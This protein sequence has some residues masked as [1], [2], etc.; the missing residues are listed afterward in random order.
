MQSELEK[1]RIM[2]I[3]SLFSVATIMLTALSLASCNNRKFHVDGE[4]TNAK[5]STLYFE[6]MSLNG[7][8]V[9]DSVKLGE[10]GSFS[11]SEKAPEAPDFYRLRIAGQIINVSIDSTETVN[12]KAAYPRMASKYE[13]RGSVNCCKIKTLALMQ[14]G[15]Q[16]QI[17]DIIKSPALGVEAVEANIAS[18]LET[19][20]NKVKLNYI[21]REPM[22]AYAYFALF[23]TVIIGNQ[24]TLIFNPR[25]N[26]EDNKV[27]AAVAT[28][29]D[30]YYPKAERGL[31]L[32]NIALQGMKDA[33]ILQAE[34]Q[35]AQID[36]SKV[37][38]SG[39]I[40]IALRDNKGN[41]R[42]L[43]DLTG[44]VVMLD[45]HV[46]AG[47]NSTKR[48]MMLRD[49]YNKY[50][51]QGFEIYQVSI[52]PDEHFWK[53]QTAALPWISVHDDAGTD[54]QVLSQY[55]VQSIP[56]FFLIGKD[57]SVKMRDVQVKDIDAAI[58]SLL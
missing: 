2:K 35:Q 37:K 17:D 3:K 51:A 54:S 23:Q 10:D 26:R 29:W 27:Y 39:I 8:V 22:K 28:S 46:F 15:L 47:E 55:N 38:V 19:Y 33:R 25:N 36:A 42:R 43:S 58:K 49:L 53:T 41:L 14:Q 30:T 20:K 9:V 4:I 32:H 5:D 50:H 16:K 13:V 12:I 44:K 21:F 34:Q 45:F 48:I 7:P 11:F 1:T 24:Q 31:N 40:D 6:N 56:T 57:N 18:A 52:D